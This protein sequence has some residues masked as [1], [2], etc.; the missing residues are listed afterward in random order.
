MVRAVIF[1]LNGV[2]IQSPLLSERFQKDFGV[3]IDKFV[4]ALSD[5]MSKA[6]LPKARDVFD[7]W[8]P[9][10]KEWNVSL[11]REKFFD[12]WFGAEK[13]NKT[14]VDYV[15]KL[16][17]KG[18]KIFALSNNFRERTDYYA[19][20]FKF[21]NKVF[22]GVYYSWQ[23]GFAKPDERAYRMILDDNGLKASDCFYFDDSDKNVESAKKLGIN[24]FKFKNL[25][26]I[27]KVLG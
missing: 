19:Q 24:A 22:D 25:D 1:D 16:K 15:L 2:F 20:N 8:K 4:P 10:F 6:R 14:M 3:S 23:T 21:L 17:K 27:V 5:V 9:Y 18:Y 13:E 7:Y 26:E 12:Y 11:D